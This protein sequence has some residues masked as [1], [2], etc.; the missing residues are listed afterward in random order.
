MTSS[1]VVSAYRG[2]ERSIPWEGLG[3]QNAVGAALFC[4]VLEGY[5]PK[6]QP[7][8]AEGPFEQ[9]GVELT[10][11]VLGVC[12]DFAK[13]AVLGQDLI[14]IGD[15]VFGSKWCQ[16]P[17]DRPG[18]IR[19]LSYERRPVSSAC[20]PGKLDSLVA[21]AL[22]ALGQEA[23]KPGKPANRKAELYLLTGQP[24][25]FGGLAALPSA[26]PDREITKSDQSLKMPVRD[27]PVHPHRFG[28]VF[29]RPFRLVHKKIEKD[30]TTG[31]ILK[32]ADGPVDFGQLILC[33]P[34]SLGLCI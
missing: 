25:E 3:G 11:D 13:D 33:H 19:W 23:G 2:F 34:S 17:Q 22:Q 24:I 1:S 31:R 8:L 30:T 29:H 18:R 32:G 10:N 14:V 26:L 20:L 9:A 27:C 4:V 6:R 28:Y 5:G 16:L 15:G 12:A 21:L 7:G